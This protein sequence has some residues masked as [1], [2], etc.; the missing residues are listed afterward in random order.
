MSD[1]RKPSKRFLLVKHSQGW[2]CDRCSEWMRASEHEAA[3][4]YPADGE[5]FPDVEHYAGVI[6]FG[7][8]GSANDVQHEWVAQEL[9]FIES[10]LQ[11]Q[12]A[13]FGICLGAQM[14]AR[15]LGAPVAPHATRLREV[16]FHLVYPTPES[17]DFLTHPMPMMQWHSEGFEM[18]AG[19]E[20]IA[21]SDEFPNQAFRQSASVLGVQF[22]PEVNPQALALWHERNRGRPFGVLD[23]CTRERMMQDALQ[24]DDDITAW[25]GATLQRWTASA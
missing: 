4:C 23:T 15:V 18:P 6:V 16:G 8:A 14:L 1:A 24:N 20:R 11:H 13:F 19:C 17:G 10:C 22:H 9:K 2:D 3:W 12:R 7:G 5:A 25:L 21:T